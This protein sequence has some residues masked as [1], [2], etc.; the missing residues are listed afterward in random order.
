MR[1]ILTIGQR[2]KI[3]SSGTLGKVLAIGILLAVP[4]LGLT[5]LSSDLF[6]SWQGQSNEA[7]SLAN[8]SIE[9]LLA[10]DAPTSTLAE[11]QLRVQ[12]SSASKAK[13]TAQPS[14]LAK[15][16]RFTA[17][18]ANIDQ[19]NGFMG[20]LLRDE[21][22]S[23][24]TLLNAGVPANVVNS[25]VLQQIALNRIVNQDLL[26]IAQTNPLNV[27]QINGFIGNIAVRDLLFDA[28]LSAQGVSS[29][30]LSLILGQ[31]LGFNEVISQFFLLAAPKPQ[32]MV[33][34]S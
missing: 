7:A 26:T 33:S 6:A 1:F 23:D 18:P 34:P 22:I 8:D 15:D 24:L 12:G 21:F 9:G 10:F 3:S 16:W 5:R 11:H 2:L 30:A 31:Q 27:Q 14:L 17:Q 4:T 32:Q 25:V 28:A 20:T 29:H 13:E 19:I